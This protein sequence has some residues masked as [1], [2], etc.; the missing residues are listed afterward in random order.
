MHSSFMQ[1]AFMRLS[2]YFCVFSKVNFC[3]SIFYF[4]SEMCVLDAKQISGEILTKYSMY[5]V[6]PGCI[7]VVSSS[8]NLFCHH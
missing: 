4:L 5:S 6:L 2:V 8:C 7:R 1:I 3:S